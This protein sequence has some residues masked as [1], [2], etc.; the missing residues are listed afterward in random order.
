MQIPNLQMA[1]SH[2]GTIEYSAKVA[3]KDIW[4]TIETFKQSILFMPLASNLDK[5]ISVYYRG[6]PK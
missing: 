6:S 5:E 2:Y 3:L 1:H 4:Q